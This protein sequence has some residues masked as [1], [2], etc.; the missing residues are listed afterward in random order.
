MLEWNKAAGVRRL[1]QASLYF[2][3]SDRKRWAR[4]GQT[5]NGDACASGLATATPAHAAPSR[6]SSPLAPLSPA[7]LPAAAAL[8]LAAAARSSPGAGP[9]A[10]GVPPVLTVRARPRQAPALL[11]VHLAGGK[12]GGV[13]D[14]G[15]AHQRPHPPPVA[16]ELC[17]LQERWCAPPPPLPPPSTTWGWCPRHPAPA[18]LHC[19]PA[20]RTHP[21]PSSHLHPLCSPACRPASPRHQAWPLPRCPRPRL[22]RLP[23]R[24]GVCVWSHQSGRCA[25]G[26]LSHA[27]ARQQQRSVAD[28][29]PALLRGRAG[30]S[31]GGAGRGRGRRRAAGEGGWVWECGEG[32]VIT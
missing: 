9:A 20:P 1:N 10:L 12:R 25:L 3:A 32:R 17:C 4:P 11:Y 13:G 26:H 16:C 15:Q 14:A 7:A 29:C 2:T 24:L 23:S 19:P 30:A 6:P 22:L 27:Q 31:M 8:A 5:V 18:S 21:T 28:S